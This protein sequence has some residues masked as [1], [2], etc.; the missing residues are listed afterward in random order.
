M[1]FKQAKTFVIICR[2]LFICLFDTCRVLKM[3]HLNHQ[4][5]FSQQTL[6]FLMTMKQLLKSH[7]G[8]CWGQ[9]LMCGARPLWYLWLTTAINSVISS[10][11]H[12]KC[13]AMIAPLDPWKSHFEWLLVNR[14]I[15]NHQHHSIFILFILCV[16]VCLPYNGVKTPERCAWAGNLKICVW[17]LQGLWITEIEW[18]RMCVR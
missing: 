8:S 5:Q 13:K 12:T 9:V 7:R 14:R 18:E 1:H 16:C 15:I 4:R 6:S 3:I 17:Q 11:Q 10:N 2:V